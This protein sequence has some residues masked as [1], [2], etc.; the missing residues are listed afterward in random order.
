MTY[1]RD[2][3]WCDQCCG[4]VRK[5]TRWEIVR[6]TLSYDIFMLL[7]GRIALGPLGRFF[8]QY[9]GGHA[10]TCDCPAKVLR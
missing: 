9:A 10:F 1:L 6:D 2:T 4:P 7:P 5:K 3:Y 8:L